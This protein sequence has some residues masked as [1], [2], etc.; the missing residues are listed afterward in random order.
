MRAG[1]HAWMR[2]LAA[3][4][5]LALG[6]SVAC[7]QNAREGDQ[8]TGNERR[9]DTTCEQAL[10]LI[11]NR[12]FQT[13]RG[14]PAGCTVA[15]LA[16]RHPQL[17]AGNGLTKLG[18]ELAPAEFKTLQLGAYRKPLRVFYRQDTV[19]AIEIEYPEIENGF[20]AL[21]AIFGQPAATLD[22]YQRT[23]RYDKSAY[24]YPDRGIAVFYDPSRAAV[25]RLYLFTPTT[26]EAYQRSL[27]PPL[28]PARRLP[29]R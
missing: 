26:L 28:T 1:R 10:A 22:Y 4:C 9:M 16:A 24:V 19:V 13:W 5:T 7:A 2:R 12:D 20:A 6:A 8:R 21:S 23:V 27:H 15:E 11:E 29:A 18:S 14:L 25:L 17:S 3:G